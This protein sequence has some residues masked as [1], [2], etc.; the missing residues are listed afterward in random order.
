MKT[1]ELYRWRYY[2]PVRKK[3]CTT[4]YVCTEA[5]ARERYGE[6]EKVGAPEARQVPETPEE[7][8]STSTSAWMRGCGPRPLEAKPDTD[9]PPQ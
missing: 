1:L 4:R 8:A 2:D 7:H 6:A 3:H 9:E 5:E